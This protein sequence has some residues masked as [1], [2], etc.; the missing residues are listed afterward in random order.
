[1][2]AQAPKRMKRAVIAL[3]SCLLS[4]CAADYL[5]TGLPLLEGKPVSQA[6]HYLGYPTE[7]KKALGQTMYSW[8]SYQ[9][10]GFWTP[11]QAFYPVIVQDQGHPAAVLSSPGT[12]GIR[13]TYS[14]SCRLDIVADKDIIIHTQYQDSGG[15]CRVF[16]DKL[17]PLAAAANEKKKKSAE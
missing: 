3:F 16:S 14:W 2:N 5:A 9:S 11:D 7:E 13:E 8:L 17:K 10:G 1:M 15:G 6:V 4:G 12:P